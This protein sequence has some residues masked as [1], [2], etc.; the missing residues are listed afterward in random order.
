MESYR[1]YTGAIVT[2]R[3]RRFMVVKEAERSGGRLFLRIA[4]RKIPAKG[5]RDLNE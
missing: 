3:G 4:Q 5:E 1:I 2:K